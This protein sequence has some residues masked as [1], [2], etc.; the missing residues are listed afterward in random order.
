MPAPLLRSVPAGFNPSFGR[1][2]G[3]GFDVD[4]VCVH[5]AFPPVWWL[6][7]LSVSSLAAKGK[8]ATSQGGRKGAETKSFCGPMQK[9]FGGVHLPLG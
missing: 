2:F 3:G 4:V 9:V 1:F 5:S 7:H 6:I 8:G